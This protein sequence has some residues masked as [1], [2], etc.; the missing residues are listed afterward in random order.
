MAASSVGNIVFV[1]FHF[2]A[3]VRG[4]KGMEAVALTWN[5]AY[6]KVM[7]EKD[8]PE[9]NNKS[10]KEKDQEDK[11]REDGFFNYMTIILV[12]WSLGI[13]LYGVKL[14]SKK[15]ADTDEA[16]EPKPETQ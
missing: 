1:P 3:A 5:N 12:T 7:A 8:D 6:H 15:V 9:Y 10:K 4:V 14:M 13:T 16:A 11:K 2:Y